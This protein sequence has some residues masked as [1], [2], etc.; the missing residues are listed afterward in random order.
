MCGFVGV[1][2]DPG[3]GVRREEFAPALP[4]VIAVYAAL[5]VGLMA[6]VGV[7][8]SRLGKF[9]KQLALVEEAL[10]KRA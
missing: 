6:Y 10:E 4:F 7:T 9:E 1:I 5:W 3:R 8:L 2:R